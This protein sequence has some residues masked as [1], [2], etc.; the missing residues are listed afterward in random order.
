MQARAAAE[1]SAKVQVEASVLVGKN[2]AMAADNAK[3]KQQLVQAQQQVQTTQ[4]E[5]LAVKD[6]LETA[7]KVV[8]LNKP[9]EG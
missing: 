9:R 5:L 2:S 1:H 3:L 4:I 8:A 7:A 6:K